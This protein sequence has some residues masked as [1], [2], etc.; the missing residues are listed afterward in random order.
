[1]PNQ[2]LF[3]NRAFAPADVTTIR[4]NE[5]C[6]SVGTLPRQRTY[7]RA[8]QSRIEAT[9]DVVPLHPVNV[10]VYRS[11]GIPMGKQPLRVRNQGPRFDDF[12]RVRNRSD[13]TQLRQLALSRQ[14]PAE[15]FKKKPKLYRGSADMIFMVLIALLHR[16]EST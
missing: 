1:M 13:A 14:S 5:I 7:W 15:F 4:H 3:S 8:G 12:G 11:I 2:P 10:L 6:R 16:G 9:K